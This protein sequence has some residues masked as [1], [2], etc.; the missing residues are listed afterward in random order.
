MFGFGKKVEK[1]PQKALENAEKTLN[2]GITGALTKGFMGKDFVNQMNQ[3][4]SMGKGA[5]ENVQMA[6]ILA[7]SGMEGSA[8]VL[9]I[10]DTGALVNYNPVVKLTLK[11]APAYGT[12]FETTGQSMVSKIAIPRVG[13]KI[14]I[15]YNPNDTTQ[16]VVV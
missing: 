12:A 13:D 5:M 2:T 3:S 1:D 16:F 6:Q 4:I 11:V 15:K 14:K 9:A 7:Q 10:E 8:E